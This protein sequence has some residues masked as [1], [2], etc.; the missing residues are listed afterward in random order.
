MTI[1]HTHLTAEDLFRMP[2]DGRR[3]ELIHGELS[4]MTPP[5]GEHCSVMN[6]IGY[7]LT[8]HVRPRGL[9]RVLTGDPGIIIAR[10]PDHVR[11]PDVCFIARDRI[12]PEGIP[13]GYVEIVPDLIVEVVSPSDSAEEVEAKIGEWLAAG[14]RL[15]WA[16]YPRT[17]RVLA[18]QPGGIARVYTE[19]DTIDGAPVL[20]EFTCRVGE[21]FE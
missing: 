1:Q 4:E 6:M 5:G 19:E 11:A 16:V 2:D 3:Y 20:P 9:G 13:R 14:A 8:H 21:F 7:L 12:P 10:E 18:H 17:R 15:V